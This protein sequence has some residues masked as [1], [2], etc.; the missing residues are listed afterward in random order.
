MKPLRL[1]LALLFTLLFIGLSTAYAQVDSTS[2]SLE[3]EM[4]KTF[5]AYPIL[6]IPDTLENIAEF[7]PVIQKSLFLTHTNRIEIE[8]RQHFPCTDC[9]PFRVIHLY[10]DSVHDII[11]LTD[12]N[13]IAR[14]N[15]DSLPITDSNFVLANELN[16]AILRFGVN[17]KWKF[18]HGIMTRIVGCYAVDE[19]G[20]VKFKMKVEEMNQ[21]WHVKTSDVP[22]YIYSESCRNG[23]N[24]IFREVE[25]RVKAKNPNTYAGHDLVFLFDFDDQEKLYLKIRNQSCLKWAFN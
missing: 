23:L 7:Y 25:S 19:Y 16:E 11:P 12:F 3:S 13:R 10:T 8:L 2:H 24:S 20:L 17:E 15:K 6:P 22:E 21:K 9:D 18:L 5:N 14:I 4:Q 1:K